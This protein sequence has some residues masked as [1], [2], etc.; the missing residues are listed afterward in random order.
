LTFQQIVKAQPE[1]P[2]PECNRWFDAARITEAFMP[3]ILC[4]VNHFLRAK[5]TQQD[6]FNVRNYYWKSTHSQDNY[7]QLFHRFTSASRIQNSQHFYHW[8]FKQFQFDDFR[9]DIDSYLLTQNSS[10]EE[11]CRR[12][13]NQNFIAQDPMLN[14]VLLCSAILF[15]N[16]PFELIK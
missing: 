8:L 5:A 12:G 1:L 9:L 11:G 6:T 4:R 13:N 2:A 3:N 16:K 10:G 14:Q 7:K 15:Q